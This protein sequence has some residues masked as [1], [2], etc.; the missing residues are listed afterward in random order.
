MFLGLQELISITKANTILIGLW[1]A[2]SNINW[3]LVPDEF[4][5]FDLETTGLDPFY[6]EIIEIGAVR[7]IKDDYIKTGQVETFQSFIKPDIPISSEVTKINSITNDMVKDGDSLEKALNDFIS[8]AGG[9][10]L[11]AYNAKFDI[12]FL[13]SSAKKANVKLPRPLDYECALELA[14]AKLTNVPNYKLTTIAELF[15]VSTTGAHRALDDCVMTL[16]VYINCINVEKTLRYS[17]SRSN[18]KNSSSSS[19]ESL[20][21]ELLKI[22]FT[23]L[24][25]IIGGLLSLMTKKRR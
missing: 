15:K 17:G 1:M 14:R 21:G 11:I 16:H 4:I 24:G 8:F 2:D 7:F 22:I 23:I 25:A 19:K 12:K 13:R 9:R 20:F 10:K 18:K 6:S 3:S 5:I